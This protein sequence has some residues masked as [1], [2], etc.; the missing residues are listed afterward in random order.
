[1][2]GLSITQLIIISS[3]N[4]TTTIRA[5]LARLNSR[6]WACCWLSRCASSFDLIREG[7][8]QESLQ[9][10]TQ[11]D[12]G[13]VCGDDGLPSQ[14]R[15]RCVERAADSQP[16]PI[17]RPRS[18]IYPMED[19]RALE[20]LGDV[21]DGINSKLL[22]VALD[23][24]LESLYQSGFLQVS[25]ACYERLKRISPASMDRLRAQ[26]GASS[27]RAQVAQP[28]QAGHLAQGSDSDSHLGRV[29]RRPSR[30]HR[31]GLGRP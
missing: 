12:S 6:A 20:K 13:R 21:F 29:E 8:L 9:E 7:L 11:Q 3:S 19:A 1:M 31:D 4:A 15:D 5:P 30:L 26:H 10:R 27:R 14:A 25:R 22:R 17:R 23:N 16:R 2:R 24:E 28:H 18:A